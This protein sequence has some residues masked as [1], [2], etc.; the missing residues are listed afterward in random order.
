MILGLGHNGHIGFNEPSDIFQKET[1]CV[2]L[3]ESMIMRA[4]KI[5]VVVSGAD[6][7]EIVKKVFFGEITPQITRLPYC[8]F[9]M[10][11]SLWLMRMR[12]QRT[13][14]GC[15]QSFFD[16]FYCMNKEHV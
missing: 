8:S 11:S 1:H 12:C 16:T 15:K 9:I 14:S 10:M 4:K 13:D 6:K 5:L 2:N 3:T 7:A